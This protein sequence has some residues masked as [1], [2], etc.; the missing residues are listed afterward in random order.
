MKTQLLFLLSLIL[1]SSVV[2]AKFE[3]DEG[4]VI[5]TDADF[6]EFISKNTYVLV[7]FYAPWCGHCQHLA[8]EYSAAA[9]FFKSENSVV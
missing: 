7:K 2:F 6:D 4:V 8:P 1:F 9:K 3:E 5:L